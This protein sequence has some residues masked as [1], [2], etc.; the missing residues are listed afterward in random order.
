MNTE[1]E[2][3]TS[4]AIELAGMSFA[5]LVVPVEKAVFDDR[6]AVMASRLAARWDLPMRVVHVGGVPGAQSQYG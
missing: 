2:M 1:M 5:E 3:T 4:D 6:G